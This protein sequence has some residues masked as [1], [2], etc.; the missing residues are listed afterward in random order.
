MRLEAA[1]SDIINSFKLE[2]TLGDYKQIDFPNGINYDTEREIAQQ[3]DALNQSPLGSTIPMYFLKK[4][5]SEVIVLYKEADGTNVM[6]YAKR[7]NGKWLEGEKRVK[8][9]P[10]L[11]ID[12]ITD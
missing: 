7:A 5:L 9:S 4:D 11:D 6:K 10:I 2:S 1:Y 8:G 12:K 3:F